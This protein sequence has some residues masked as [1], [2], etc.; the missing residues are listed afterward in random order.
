M[1]LFCIRSQDCFGKDWTYFPNYANCG[2]YYRC[3]N[4]EAVL[5]SCPEALLF[6]PNNLTCN[7]APSV[8]CY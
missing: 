1:E 5:Y 4:N 8:Q 6:D 7:W 2:T 3:E